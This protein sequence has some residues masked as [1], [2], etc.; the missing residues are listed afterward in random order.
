MKIF[1]QMGEVNP[2]VYIVISNGAWLS[3][4]WLQHCDAVWMINAGD[5]AGSSRTKELVYRDGVY[6]NIWMKEKTHYP[7]NSLFNH[8]LKGEDG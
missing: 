8:S 7:M 3:P 5:A 2:D 4:W 6:H 1:K